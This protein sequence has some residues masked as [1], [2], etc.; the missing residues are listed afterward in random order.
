MIRPPVLFLAV[1]AFTMFSLSTVS[2]QSSP[3]GPDPT[4]REVSRAM[5]EGRLVN[6]EKILDDAI[7]KLEQDDST[8]P[9][10]AIYLGRLA[11]LYTQ[12]HHFAEAL[13]LLQRVLKNDEYSF[14]FSD[15]RVAN[16]LSLI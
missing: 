8:N 12:K 7:H 16:D 5:N 11:M 4:M 1:A 3:P 9:R 15:T 14:G 10:L 6:A 2:G 13:A